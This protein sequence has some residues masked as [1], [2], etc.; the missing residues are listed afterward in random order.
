MNSVQ[1]HLPESSLFIIGR[2]FLPEVPDEQL[3]LNRA[4]ALDPDALAQ[5]HDEFYKPIF[6]T[7]SFRVNDRATAEDLTSEVFTRL[8]SALRQKSAPQR[9][10]RGWLFAVAS[11]VVK[12][13]YRR[14]YRQPETELHE[15]IPHQAPTPEQALDQKMAQAQLDAA[16]ETLTEEQ[17]EVL[18][19]RFGYEMPIRDVAHTLEKSEGA[20][21]MLQARAI[22]A[23]TRRLNPK[24]AN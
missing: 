6:R 5:I 10:L 12:D 2:H 14:Q 18:A 9:T 20:I 13:H 19:L 11:Y 3:L 22:A 4:R 16:L 1:S 23:L 8:L 24:E 7:I 15:Q 17:Q 21:K